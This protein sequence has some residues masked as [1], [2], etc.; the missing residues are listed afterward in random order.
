MT[1][2]R[3]QTQSVSTDRRR[4]PRSGPLRER[5]RACR[6][7]D[8]R[9]DARADGDGNLPAARPT[10]SGAGGGTVAGDQRDQH[11]V[12][13]D[14][15]VPRLLHAGRIRDA[16]GWLRAIAR[17]GEYPRRRDRR[18]RHL[19]RH[20]LGLGLRVHVRA[21]EWLY[22]HDAD[23]FSTAFPTRMARREFHCS[24]S[25][26]SSSR[27]PTPARRLPLAP[28]WAAADSWGTSSTASA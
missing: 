6:R 28:W 3:E 22:R 27:S 8:H 4:F 16:G 12:G 1:T 15:C 10:R 11:D 9:A 17:V 24:P 19:R 18:H 2:T 20:V 23:S 21:G 25:G 5:A 26:C 13:A 14:C 7:K